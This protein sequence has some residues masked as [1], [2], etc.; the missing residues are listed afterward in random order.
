MQAQARSPLTEVICKAQERIEAYSAGDER[1]AALSDLK[2]LVVTSTHAKTAFGELGLRVIFSLIR[3]EREDAES[4]R[5]ALELVVAA[6]TP[7]DEA[8]P[9]PDDPAASIAQRVA[10][11]DKNIELCLSMLDETDFFLRY[12]ALQASS[13]T[14]VAPSLC[15]TQSVLL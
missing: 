10:A 6:I 7:E 13:A 15:H 1:R 12:H 11:D 5:G 4:A 14:T 3:E 2:E 9:G 8:S